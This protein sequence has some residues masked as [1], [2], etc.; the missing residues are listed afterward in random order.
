MFVNDQKWEGGSRSTLK[1]HSV[2]MYIPRRFWTQHN[3]C[4]QNPLTEISSLEVNVHAE[5]FA[6]CCAIV[7]KNCNAKIT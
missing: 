6:K 3:W 2:E 4:Q 5:Y 1:Q 7:N